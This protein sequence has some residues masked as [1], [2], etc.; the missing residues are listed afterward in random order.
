V[1]VGK[2]GEIFPARMP[3]RQQRSKLSDRHVQQR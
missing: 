1:E 2:R 3:R